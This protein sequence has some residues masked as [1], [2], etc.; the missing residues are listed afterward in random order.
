M[1]LLILQVRLTEDELSLVRGSA[2]AAT[3]ERYRVWLAEAADWSLIDATLGEDRSGLQIIAS[4]PGTCLDGATLGLQR[5]FDEVPVGDVVTVSLQVLEQPPATRQGAL[6]IRA[7]K[8]SMCR[9]PDGLHAADCPRR[10][11]AA[12]TVAG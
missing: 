2:G 5:L 11:T 10:A 8:C 4:M 7:P 3:Y 1:L 9:Y 6:L 12:E